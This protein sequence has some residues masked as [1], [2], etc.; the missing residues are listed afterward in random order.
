[1]SYPDTPGFKTEGTSQEAAADIANRASVLKIQALS[2]LRRTAAGATADEIAA[3]LGAS[4]LAIRPRISELRV[5]GLVDTNGGRRA[6]KSGKSAFIWFALSRK[7]TRKVERKRAAEG[8]KLNSVLAGALKV[9]H[10]QLAL[11][12]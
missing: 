8:R 5:E 4:I 9:A 12:A 10:E 11:W 1:M 6:N 2:F 3:A 7:A